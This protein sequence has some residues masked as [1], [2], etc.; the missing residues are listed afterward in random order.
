VV[1]KSSVFWDTKPHSPLKVNQDFQETYILQFE[2]QKMS[3]ARN[4]RERTWRAEQAGFF[5]YLLFDPEDGV[6]M[7]LRN[8][9]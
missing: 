5:F 2:S 7:F 9:C 4:K 8:V 6:G 1:K 3:R